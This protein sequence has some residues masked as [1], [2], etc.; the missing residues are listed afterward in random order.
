LLQGI[1]IVW[2]RWCVL[3][4][5]LGI[6]LGTSSAKVLLATDAGRVLAQGSAEYA[7]H[8]PQPGWAEQD[9]E[10]WWQG[11]IV[12]VRQALASVQSGPGGSVQIATIGL[13][14][15][16]HGTV[17]L[18]EAGLP[19]SPAVIWPDRRSQQQVREITDLIGAERLIELT[20]S[21][22]AT[23]FQAAT[24]LWVQQE[25][26]DLWRR[27]RLVLL[28][29]DYI[30][31][32][33]TGGICT[34]PS[35]GAGAL[36]LD[37]HLRDWAPQIL[38][39][40]GIDKTQLPPVRPSVAVVGQLASEAAKVLGLPVGIP[41]VAGAADTAC[42]TLGAG[43]IRAHGMLLTI[44]TGGQI[45][46]PALKV[47]VDRK[48]RVHTFCG[49]LE[50]RPDR[51]GWYQMAAILSAGRSLRWLRDKVF[52]LSHDA[53]YDQMTA[54][55]ETAPPGA[56]G[57]LFLPYLAGERTPH[58][59]AQARGLFL[60]LVASHGRAELVR[61]AMEGVALACYDAYQVLVELGAR[62]ERIVMA[63][64]G[65]RSRLW[66]QIIADVFDLP[67]RRLQVGE[68]SALGAILLAGGGAGLFD[69]G[70]AAQDWVAYGPPVEPDSGR[71][72]LYQS[73]LPLFRGAY[74]KC[75]EDFRQLEGVGR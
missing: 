2:M 32:R 55:A 8:H 5:L 63:G 33:L 16:M 43:I 31:Y 19:L 48:G 12:A 50:P 68:Q 9:P 1:S 73:L 64:G 25:R 17:L 75:R 28:P 62:P 24:V 38:T 44:S 56:D 49:A 21:P 11:V 10:G 70:S 13:S 26:P 46:L 57:L 39:A 54:W 58:M 51:A 29:K 34:D 7:I 47:Q 69:P 35:D 23:G 18:D 30:R 71:H 61:A 60:G 37:V 42:S 72:A 41:V 14:G 66:R 20:G 27:T 3:A 67:V 65:A 15:Q 6:D 59:D 36:L 74:R 22:L 52:D 40:L 45:V 4:H 53:G